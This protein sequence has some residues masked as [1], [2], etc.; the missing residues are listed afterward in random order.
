V[1]DRVIISVTK[2]CLPC[3]PGGKSA[4]GLEEAGPAGRNGHALKRRTGQH[5]GW[6]GRLEAKATVL[7]GPAT[8]PWVRKRGK[9][10][11]SGTPETLQACLAKV[12]IGRTDRK[13]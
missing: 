12:G 11:L 9:G 5:T 6:W 8:V 10:R 4:V 1:R 2:D 7:C 3:P 13:G